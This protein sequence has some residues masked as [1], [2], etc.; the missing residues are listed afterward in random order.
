VPLASRI[1][2][3]VRAQHLT[4]GYAGYWDAA[5]ID[6]SSHN[7]L[8]VYPL[9]DRFG[10]T[11]PMYLARVDAWYRPRRHT[12]TYLLLAPG[13]SNLVDRLPSDLPRPQREFQVGPVTMAV[14]PY[15]LAAYLHPPQ[16]QRF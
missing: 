8:H 13:D 15:D 3:L 2:A 5:S 1:E 9:T 6:W 12:P 4:V 11:E 14:Y 16:K 10:P 7:R